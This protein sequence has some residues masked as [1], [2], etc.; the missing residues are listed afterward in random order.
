MRRNGR[1]PF[2]RRA[3][4]SM[5]VSEM[6]FP[7]LR[8]TKILK[9]ENIVYIRHSWGNATPG[10]YWMKGTYVWEAYIDDVKIGETTFYVEDVGQGKEGENL[11]FDVES[12]R[13]FEG[14]GQGS[15]VPQKII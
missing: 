11:Y 8:K 4:L 13:F 12:L 14:D 3:I 1:R 2:D 15:S 6:N 9:D 5:A 7:I 10:I